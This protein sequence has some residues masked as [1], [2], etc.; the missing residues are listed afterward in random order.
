MDIGIGWEEEEEDEE[1]NNACL[2]SR[3]HFR[4]TYL[5]PWVKLNYV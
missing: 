5:C 4:S 2:I 1:A 3:R